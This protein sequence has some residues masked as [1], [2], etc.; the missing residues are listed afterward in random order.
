[1]PSDPILLEIPLPIRTPRLLIRAN[2]PG[3]G[4]LTAAAVTET[5][6]DLH[7]WMDWAECLE[8]NTPEK[9]EIRTRQV[10]AKFLLHEEFNL[11]GIE[12]ETGQPVL[13][14]G[15]HNINWRARHCDTGYWVRKS[16]QN[17]GLATEATNALLRYAFGPLGMQRVGISHAAGNERSR[18]VIEKLGFTPEGI[19]HKAM[20]LPGNRFTDRHLYARFDLAGLPDLDVTWG[21]PDSAPIPP[22]DRVPRA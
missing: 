8:D 15:F 17:R 4:A 19:Q 14:C 1:M 6:D 11:V 22:K 20:Q 16:A 7:L 13:W 21:E 12:L 18:R 5:W 2:Q 3:D 9:Q 10:M